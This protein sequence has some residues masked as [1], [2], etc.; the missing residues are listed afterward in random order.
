MAT[1][2][3]MFAGRKR[4]SIVWKHFQYNV[5]NNKS[6]CTVL[7]EKGERECGVLVAGKNPTNMKAH[8]V[9]H[10]PKISTEVQEQE[11]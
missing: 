6:M 11:N 5:A 1:F 7:D 3:Q 9:R 4:E 10:H 2:S 8:L